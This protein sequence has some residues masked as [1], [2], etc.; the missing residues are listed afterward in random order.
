MDKSIIKLITSDDWKLR[1][2]GEYAEVCI[3]CERLQRGLEEISDRLP[4]VREEV[5]NDLSKQ[6]KAMKEYGK[7]LYKRMDFLEDVETNN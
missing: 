6:L 1:L 2:L 7:C 3:R 5:R 4:L